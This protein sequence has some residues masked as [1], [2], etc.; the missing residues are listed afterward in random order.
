MHSN[1]IKAVAYS[2]VSTLLG[3]DPELQL[4]SIGLI[5]GSSI[6][7]EPGEVGIRQI[8]LKRKV[9]ISSLHQR[10][11]I[12]FDH[13]SKD[14]PCRCSSL[15]G[16]DYRCLS[17]CDPA[18]FAVLQLVTAEVTSYSRRLYSQDKSW[19]FGIEDFIWIGECFSY[20]E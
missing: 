18:S 16:T 8:A 19:Q 13:F 12:S 14:Q 3:Q 5:C 15:F 4:V 1:P 17:Y 20:I 10:R 2:R 7:C 6:G 9:F 11:V